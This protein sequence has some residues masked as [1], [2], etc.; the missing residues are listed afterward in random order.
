[1]N[2]GERPRVADGE[3]GLQTW[4][5]SVD[6]LNKQSQTA[7]NMLSSSLGAGREANNAS[8]QKK[9]KKAVTRG[10]GFCR[11]FLPR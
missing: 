10:L 2:D 5:V 4:W 1:M 11:L 9:K 7:E 6:I 8:Q 3:D